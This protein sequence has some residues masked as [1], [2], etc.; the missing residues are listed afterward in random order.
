MA[1][2]REKELRKFNHQN[3]NLF[4]LE[5]LKAQDQQMTDVTPIDNGIDEEKVSFFNI[6]Q[7]SRK[8][9][10]SYLVGCLNQIFFQYLTIVFLDQGYFGFPQ[11]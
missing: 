4:T 11:R 8:I 9:D 5:D 6:L 2:N 1:E 3:I 7:P 10:F